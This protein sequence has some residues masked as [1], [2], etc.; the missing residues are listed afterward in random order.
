[1]AQEN[2]HKDVLDLIPTEGF[3]KVSGIQPK[4]LKKEDKVTLIRKGN[5]LFN[6]GKYELAK[7]I[8]NKEL[9]DDFI[10]LLNKFIKK[11]KTDMV[12]LSKSSNNNNNC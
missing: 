5:E 1:M 7:K 9:H 2:N 10:K 4:V 3:I 12:R 8:K 6:K 11:E